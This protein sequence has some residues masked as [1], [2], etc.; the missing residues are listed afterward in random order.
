MFHLYLRFL[1]NV[2]CG[3]TGSI[4]VYYSTTL[5]KTYV[6]LSDPGF[7]YYGKKDGKKTLSTNWMS[8]IQFKIGFSSDTKWG[9]VVAASGDQFAIFEKDASIQQTVSEFNVGGIY[10]VSW[11]QMGRPN[12]AGTNDLNVMLGN[13]IIFSQSSVSST[14]GWVRKV[15][16][17]FI[18]TSTSHVLK[19]FSTNPRSTNCAVFLDSIVIFKD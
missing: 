17:Q 10:Y 2:D 18:A 8:P 6:N 3:S 16:G 11:I 9:S 14:E 12:V 4:S 15:S 19:I 1:Y 13:Q 7:D 5:R